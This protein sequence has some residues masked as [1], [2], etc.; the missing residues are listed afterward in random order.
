M[1]TRNGHRRRRCDEQPQKDIQHCFGKITIPTFTVSDSSS[2]RAW[3]QKLDACFLLN[4]KF[5]EEAIK[6]ANLHLEGMTHKWRYHGMMAQG[7]DSI[8]TLEDFSETLI[9]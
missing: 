4:P 2:A 6:F 7:K 8:T 9:K 1:K 5:E 3:L